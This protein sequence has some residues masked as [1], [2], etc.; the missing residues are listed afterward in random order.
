M[1]NS[2]ELQQQTQAQQN[3]CG[4]GMT[5]NHF[6]LKSSLLEQAHY[7]FHS[8]K[9]ILKLNIYLLGIQRHVKNV[10]DLLV[11]GEHFAK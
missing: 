3:W 1:S 10:W 8:V 2:E 5:N 11:V 4:T 9:H 6:N 7:V